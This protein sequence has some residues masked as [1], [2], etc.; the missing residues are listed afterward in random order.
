MLIFG[1]AV[2]FFSLEKYFFYFSK[3]FFADFWCCGDIFFLRDF[4]FI[5]LRIFVL[6]FGVAVAILSLQKYVFSSI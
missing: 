5:S 3:V 4:F 6:I 1:V 2:T